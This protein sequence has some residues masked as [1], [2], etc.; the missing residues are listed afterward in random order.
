MPQ[1]DG[2]GPGG[3][4]SMTG[5]GMGFCLLAEDPD[6]PG[7]TRGYAGISGK[8]VGLTDGQEQEVNKMP[9]GNGTGPMG[10]GPMT[11]RGAGYCAGYGMPG[12]M[13][14]AFGGGMGFGRGFGRGRG[15]GWRNMFYATGLPGYARFGAGAFAP[16]A[17]D[18]ALEKQALKNQAEALRSEMEAI[19]KRL[20][21]LESPASE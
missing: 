14:P 2:T 18:P 6:Q 20:E 3:K 11:G 15:R 16:T 5:R 17:P 10:M 1:G 13:N 9:A 8:P 7:R 21:E 4:G 19:R 12:Y